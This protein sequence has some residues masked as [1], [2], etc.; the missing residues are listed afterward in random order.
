MEHDTV[1][2][3]MIKHDGPL[4]QFGYIEMYVVV[5]RASPAL[6]VPKVWIHV[7]AIP[8]DIHGEKVDAVDIA[9]EC[10]LI[11]SGTVMVSTTMLGAW[12]KATGLVSL[13]ALIKATEH[14]FG[15]GALSEAN[16]KSIKMA[17]EQFEYVN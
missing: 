9:R 13:D 4:M 14:Q 10:G 16:I 3:G 17:Y 8:T 12:A 7:L 11:K 1:A 2:L 5:F 15:K 6:D